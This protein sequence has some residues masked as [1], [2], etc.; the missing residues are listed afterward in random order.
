MGKNFV[1]SVKINRH[2]SEQKGGAHQG[3]PLSPLLDVL[4]IEP[5]VELIRSDE[6]VHIPGGSG[7]RVKV[8]QYADDKCFCQQKEG[9]IEQWNF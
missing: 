8:L 5:L 4:F 1:S 6:R 9:W 2:L 3:C 7:E